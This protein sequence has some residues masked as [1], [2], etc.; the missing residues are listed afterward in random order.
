MARDKIFHRAFTLMELIIVTIIIGIIAAFA[1]PNYQKSIEKSYERRE[2]LNLLAINGA[3]AIYKAKNGV[4]FGG[5]SMTIPEINAGLGLNLQSDGKFFYSCATP[6][7]WWYGCRATRTDW[8]YQ[9][10]TGNG[11]D[12]KNQ[13]IC[14]PPCCDNNGGDCPSIPQCVAGGACCP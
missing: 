8:V 6:G 13:I 2:Y 14:S 3:Q 7:P 11:R 10:C 4:Y 5:G 12:I 9:L 1:I